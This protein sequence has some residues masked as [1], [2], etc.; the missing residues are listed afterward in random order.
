MGFAEK[1]YNLRT[2]KGLSQESLAEQFQISRQS[3]SKWE[4]G[5]ALPETDKLPLISNFF[6]VS[7][8]YLLHDDIS[9]N[10]DGNLSYIVVKFMGITQDMNKISN[11]L[12]DIMRDG[13]ID[14]SE[15]KCLDSLTEALDGIVNT[16]YEVKSTMNSGCVD[17][18]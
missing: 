14:E 8:D 6:N 5:D 9:D 2:R 1:F 17:Q 18:K 7:I 15:R 11:E 10:G 12:V 13:V 4:T 3:I 16:I